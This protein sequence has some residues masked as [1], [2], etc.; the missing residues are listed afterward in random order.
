VTT[1]AALC[2]SDELPDCA[3]IPRSAL[4]PALNEQGY[5]VGRNLY[6]VTDGVYNSA[7]LI[8]AD[9]PALFDAPLSIPNL[10][11]R[12]VAAEGEQR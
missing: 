2:S 8:T 1:S 4:G 12:R 9:D 10:S 3:S 6:W 11:H 7:F 5:H